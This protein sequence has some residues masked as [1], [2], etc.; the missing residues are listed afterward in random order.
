MIGDTF[1]TGCTTWEGNN[2]ALIMSSHGDLYDSLVAACEAVKAA[3][4]AAHAHATGNK[5]VLL[6]G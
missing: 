5:H 6:L 2:V 4:A 1:E 3:R